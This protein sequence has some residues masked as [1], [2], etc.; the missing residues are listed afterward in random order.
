MLNPAYEAPA[1]LVTLLRVENAHGKGAYRAA[2]ADDC[3]DPG[4]HPAPD[5]DPG[6]IRYSRRTGGRA[7][8]AFEAVSRLILDDATWR[9][10]GPLHFAFGSVDQYR[11][12]F[13]EGREHTLRRRGA[14]VVILHVPPECCFI[15]R[16]QAVYDRRHA[17]RAHFLRPD[18]LERDV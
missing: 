15:G 6:F 2:L 9:P 3:Y 13:C 1:G 10:D 11:R 18:T 8:E 17:V 4:V 5:A 14:L 16:S 7:F 12:W